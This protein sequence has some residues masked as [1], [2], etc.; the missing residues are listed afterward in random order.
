MCATGGADPAE[1]AKTLHAA[2]LLGV[3]DGKNLS[4]KHR[5]PGLGRVRCYL[6]KPDIFDINDDAEVAA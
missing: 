1:V 2:K 3:G 5:L 6:V 4:A